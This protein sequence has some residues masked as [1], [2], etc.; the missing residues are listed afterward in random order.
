MS[1]APHA[2]SDPVTAVPRAPDLN[3]PIADA[4]GEAM[5]AAANYADTAGRFAE[6]RDLRGLSYA[7]RSAA[8]CIGT[9]AELLSELTAASRK[10]GTRG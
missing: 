6:M 4:I 5:H 2:S 7:V 3:G 1:A 9:A 10:G 8:A